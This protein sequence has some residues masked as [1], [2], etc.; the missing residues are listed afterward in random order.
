MSVITYLLTSLRD[1]FKEHRQ[2]VLSN[3]IIYWITIK[4]FEDHEMQRAFPQ[5]SSM[6]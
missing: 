2:R 5:S 1:A 6:S 4:S 3:F